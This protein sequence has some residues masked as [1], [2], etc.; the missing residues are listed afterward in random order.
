MIKNGGCVDYSSCLRAYPVNGHC[1]TEG[2]ILEQHLYGLCDGIGAIK[3]KR[4]SSVFPWY[5]AEK[6]NMLDKMI[7]KKFI[8]PHWGK[9][10]IDKRN[11]EGCTQQKYMYYIY[12]HACGLAALSKDS[13]LPQTYCNLKF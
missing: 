4:L 1:K 8:Q 3:H 13:K 5:N 12:I 2:I 9:K 6:N 10:K 11:R 7:D